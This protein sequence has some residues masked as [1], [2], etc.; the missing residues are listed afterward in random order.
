MSFFRNVAFR[1]V[2]TVDQYIPYRGDWVNADVKTDDATDQRFA[3]NVR[4]LRQWDTEG[5]VSF[6]T[7]CTR[8]ESE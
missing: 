2:D 8:F 7:F 6:S 3:V 4:P 1:F 5:K